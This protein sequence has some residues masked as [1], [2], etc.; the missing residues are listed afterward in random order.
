MF[1]C[2]KRTDELFRTK[3]D[4]IHHKGDTPLTDLSID[5]VVQFVVGDELHHLHLVLMRKFL[6]GWKTGSF[7]RRTKWSAANMQEISIYLLSCN[8]N[9]PYEIHRKIRSISELPRWK[10]TELR[11]FLLYTSLPVL[12][13]FLPD[14]YFKHY[15]LF[16]CSIVILGSEYHYQRMIE[17]ADNMIKTFLNLFKSIYGTEHFTSNLHNLIHLV[18]EVRTFGV[19]SKFSAYSFENKMQFIKRLVRS[20]NL[21]LN[22][23]AKRILENEASVEI[24]HLDQESKIKLCRK[25]NFDCNMFKKFG[26]K[27]TVFLELQTDDFKIANTTQNQWVLT[28]NFEIL[29]VRHFVSYADKRCLF[30]GEAILDKKP[31]FDTPLDSTALLI[32]GAKKKFA[33]SKMYAIEQIACKLFCLSYFGSFHDTDMDEEFP[34]FDCIFVPLWHTLK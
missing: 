21:P 15:L 26:T 12:K 22:Q 2:T 24:E 1:E 28:R 9:K 16:Y 6:Y 14:K 23:I 3:A 5:M 33:S 4:P 10:G 17:L 8:S 19:L 25:T 13:K 7:G 27:Y 34:C 30:H 29:R 11:T 31:F 20:G 32:Y 18:E